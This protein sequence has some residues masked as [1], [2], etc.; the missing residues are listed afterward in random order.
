[1]PVEDEIIG[2]QRLPVMPFDIRL[3]FPGDRT[4][5]ARERAVFE[6]GKLGGEN[7]NEI[8]LGIPRCQRFIE[9]ARGFLVLSADCKMRVEQ[10]RRLPQQHLQRASPAALVRLVIELSLGGATP[11]Y[12]SIWL[13]SGAVSPN[14]TILRTKA[15]RDIRPAFTSAIKFRN[16]RS[17]LVWVMTLTLRESRPT[18]LFLAAFRAEY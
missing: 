16:S 9:N 1:M 6:I 12:A 14:P 4:A 3:E 17:C 8:A 5:V 2:G 15:R 11:A 10:S 7:R 18:V 13:A